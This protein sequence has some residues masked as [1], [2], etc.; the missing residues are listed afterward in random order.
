M[1]A[2]WHVDGRSLFGQGSDPFDFEEIEEL[3]VLSYIVVFDPLIEIVVYP[4]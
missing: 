1:N 2:E 4:S 3:F